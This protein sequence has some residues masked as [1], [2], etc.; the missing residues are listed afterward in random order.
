MTTRAPRAHA[1][2][3]PDW[4]GSSCSRWVWSPTKRN[5]DRE[6]TPSGVGG[7]FQRTAHQG[8]HS[9]LLCIYVLFRYTLSMII[10]TDIHLPHKKRTTSMVPSRSTRIAQTPTLPN[11]V[12][13]PGRQTGGW[14]AYR[15]G[16]GVREAHP[17]EGKKGVRGWKCK[18]SK[19]LGVTVQVSK[20]GL[21]TTRHEG[22]VGGC[23]GE[24]KEK[25]MRDKPRNMV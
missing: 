6:S 10:G 23:N 20:M 12:P 7:M 2:E 24:S 11:V 5:G 3:A 21:R 9:R 25:R 13:G 4:R 16:E 8:L 19:R 15:C 14:H 22:E 18:W 1:L 17:Q